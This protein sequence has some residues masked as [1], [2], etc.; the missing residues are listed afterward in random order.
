MVKF[1]PVDPGHL[2]EELT[3][4]S[5]YLCV[6]C[7]MLLKNHYSPFTKEWA[8]SLEGLALSHPLRDSLE[9]ERRRA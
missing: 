3:R 2:R 1:F 8:S 9:L 7:M 4:Y 6:C 5:T